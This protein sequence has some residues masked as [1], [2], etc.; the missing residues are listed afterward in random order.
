M[1]DRFAARKT[2]TNRRLKATPAMAVDALHI[3]TDAFY[4]VDLADALEY[5]LASY[6]EVGW[7]RSLMNLSMPEQNPAI[8]RRKSRPLWR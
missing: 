7:S 8:G 5:V 6:V 3:P 1:R 2:P 4:A